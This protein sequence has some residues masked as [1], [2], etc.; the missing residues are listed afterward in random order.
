MVVVTEQPLAE[1]IGNLDGVDRYLSA[2]FGPIFH[3]IRPSASQIDAQ[4]KS[5]LSKGTPTVPTDVYASAFA[6]SIGVRQLQVFLFTVSVVTRRAIAIIRSCNSSGDL[7]G[8][9]WQVRSV[10]ER[11]ANAHY[12]SFEVEKITSRIEFPSCRFVETYDYD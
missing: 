11:T 5:I 3:Y 1:F 8:I 2:K 12:L 7:L 9:L 4:L 6:S 10:L